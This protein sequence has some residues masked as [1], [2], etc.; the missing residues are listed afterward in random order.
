[1]LS[2][3]FGLNLLGN[4]NR[5]VTFFQVPIE[6]FTGSLRNIIYPKYASL[7]KN[8]E[9]FIENAIKV[10]KV[11]TWLTLPTSF[12]LAP[13]ISRLIE[14]A[15]PNH[16]HYLPQ[17]ST[18]FM[19]SL[20]SVLVATI[21]ESILEASNHQAIC[22][23]SVVAGGISIAISCLLSLVFQR[24]EILGLVPL[25][26]ALAIHAC[27]LFFAKKYIGS[28][29]IIVWKSYLPPMLLALLFNI[30]MNLILKFA[31]ISLIYFIICIFTITLSVALYS[32]IIR[33]LKV[34]RI[35]EID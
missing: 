10:L 25:S 21:F 17:L 8:N 13:A 2:R 20:T 6:Q 30:E 9:R 33:K 28:Q 35:F 3:Q 19:L 14:F 32:I 29:M 34:E 24:W 22:F 16:W 26:S 12:A 7:E 15:F 4:W 1:L 23:Y 5:A 11:L 18:F 31:E 27:Q